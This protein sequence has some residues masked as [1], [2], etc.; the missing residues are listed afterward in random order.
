MLHVIAALSQGRKRKEGE[1]FQV[2]AK[3]EGSQGV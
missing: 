3:R 1:D 2:D